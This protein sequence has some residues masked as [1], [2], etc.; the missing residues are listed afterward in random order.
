[1]RYNNKITREKQ[2]ATTAVWGMQEW[3]FFWSPL[4]M[5]KS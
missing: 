4:P 3:L 5:K 2:A 1:M